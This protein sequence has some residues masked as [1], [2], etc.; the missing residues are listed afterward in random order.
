M[1]KYMD[2]KCF[3][4]KSNIERNEILDSLQDD[5]LDILN[6]KYLWVSKIN[7]NENKRHEGLRNKAGVL[8][9]LHI[10]FASLL[11]NG[12]FFN[13]FSEFKKTELG[14]ILTVTIVSFIFGAILL[15]IYYSLK[16]GAIP[17]FVNVIDPT[18]SLESYSSKENWI[19]EVIVETLLVYKKN[20]GIIQLN[21]FRI[22]LSLD[23]LLYAVFTSILVIII[24]K[25][26]NFISEEVI[27]E[28]SIILGVCIGIIFI[29]IAR[30]VSINRQRSYGK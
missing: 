1:V 15:G 29:F 19:K 9:G 22:S 28:T 3:F 10:G 12:P 2:R 20:L 14:L 16:V 26:C 6:E 8:L 5:T 18:L 23:F 7:E 21:T 24:S 27:F 13:Q 25:A 17:R 4:Q 11:L 30:Y